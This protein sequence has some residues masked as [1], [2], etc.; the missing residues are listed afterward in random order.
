MRLVK[1]P[2]LVEA[3]PFVRELAS[4]LLARIDSHAHAHANG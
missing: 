1:K 3:Q 4:E 2:R